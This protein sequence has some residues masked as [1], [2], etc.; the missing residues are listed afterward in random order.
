MHRVSRLGLLAGFTAGLLL[1]GPSAGHAAAPGVNGWIA[2][3][4]DRETLTGSDDIYLT[5]AQATPAIRVVAD[6]GIDGN[7]AVSPDGKYLAYT[8]TV[9]DSATAEMYVCRLHTVVPR[10][11]CDETIRLTT[12]PGNESSIR[13][14]PDSQSVVYAYA[15]PGAT[16]TSG[17]T[18]IYRLVTDGTGVAQ[19]LTV[20]PPDAPLNRQVD[21]LPSVSPDGQ[22]VM[23]ASNRSAGNLDLWRMGIDGSS[24]T[25]WA[26][27]A[28]VDAGPD[29][30]PDG[31]RLV[32]ASNRDGD[33]DLYV[34]SADQPE[35]ASNPAM[36]LT[37]TSTQERLPT[38]S[39]DGTRIAFWSYPS[40]AGLTN[41]DISS[42]A[43]DGTD[44]R[45]LTAS[46][47][48]GDITPSWGG[49]PN[50]RPVTRA[51]V[52]PAATGSD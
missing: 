39:P 19:Q 15:S 24:P 50:G 35:G 36:N 2:F 25:R 28:A 30:S 52:N 51:E 16:A 29:Y 11:F 13:W 42:I 9:A 1:P 20:D 22:Y 38:W 3:V 18:D 33:L 12:T 32:F 45:D 48:G 5:T 17:N 26:S 6:A 27:T 8:S 49:S 44:R 7:P 34:I 47:A 40:G 21:T 10:P 14:A 4:S 37:D 43:Q 31:T 23:F 41:G 46:Y